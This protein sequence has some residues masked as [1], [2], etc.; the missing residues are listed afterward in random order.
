MKRSTTATRAALG[1][2]VCWLT[3]LGPGSEA[4]AG[5]GRGGRPT[6]AVARTAAP[7]PAAADVRLWLRDGPRAV[8]ARRTGEFFVDGAGRSLRPVRLEYPDRALVVD[9]FV[10][11][12]ALVEIEPRLAPEATQAD[13]VLGG[14][15]ARVVRPLM[16][17]IGLWLVEDTAGGDG[18]DLAA[19]LAEPS[20]ASRGIRQAFPNVYL[21]HRRLDAFTPNDPKLSGQWYFDKLAMT[22]AWGIERGS[23]ASSIVVVDTGCDLQH[24]DLVSKLDPGRDVVDQD[25]DP[26][27]VPTEA[28]A[29]HGTSCAGL[30]GAATDNGI[31]I[32]G[33][34][35]DCR[36]RC[37]RLLTDPATPVPAT[38]DVDAFQFA[39]DVDAAVVSNSWGFV[40]PIPVPQPLADAINNVFDNG[41]GGK[42]ALVLFA[43]GNDDRELADD[44]LEAVRGV[45]AIGAINNLD[46][47]TPFTNRGNCLD[48]V[49]YTGTLTTDISGPD[50]EDPGDYTSLFGGTSSACPVAAGIAGLLASA[51]TTQTSADLYQ[52]MI[53]TARPAPYAVPD[54]NG[55]DPI[56]GFGIIDPVAALR[57][58]LGLP[59][60]EEQPDA[61]TDAGAGG[62]PA[63]PSDLETEGGCSLGPRQP[64]GM[65]AAAPTLL[66]V[67]L[68]LARRRR[69]NRAPA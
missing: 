36:V 61:G 51:A 55:H 56:F 52:L 68:G 13:G 32:A 43:A 30:V 1:V 6:T 16:P 24:P 39:L 37:V 9:T 45:F 50:G 40:D 42:G 64:R 44:E 4:M 15:S 35:P 7:A 31:G 53:D 28:G 33:G 66:A 34:C 12:T 38:A 59:N 47:K 10:D 22:D 29:A 8:A 57:S 3:L 21:R 17:S 11:R 26:S 25:D 27:C 41:R 48:L 2:A 20:L 19:R 62:A 58:E 49:A 60:G 18:L 14:L 63:A 5:P 54:A 46:D 65:A 69:R 67:A 23:S